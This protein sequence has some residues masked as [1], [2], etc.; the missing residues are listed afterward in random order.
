VRYSGSDD[1]LSSTSGAD[2]YYYMNNFPVRNYLQQVTASKSQ[3]NYIGDERKILINKA[4]NECITID[5]NLTVYEDMDITS[6]MGFP[7]EVTRLKDEEGI[8]RING[9]LTQLKNNEQ[10]S[11]DAA[12]VVPFS[13]IAIKAGT[14]KKQ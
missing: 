6:L 3:S 5:F 9:N 12:T 4:S 10:F 8:I 2:G 1:T 13:G 11:T 7:M 14:R